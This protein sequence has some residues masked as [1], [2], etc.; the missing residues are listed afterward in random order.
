MTSIPDWTGTKATTCSWCGTDL[1]TGQERPGRTECPECGSATTDPVPDPAS[2][3]RAYGDWYWPSSGNRFGRFGDFMLRRSRASAAKRISELAPPGSI[4]D[5]GAG[6]GTLIDALGARGREASGLE[7]LP[8]RDDIVDKTIFEVEGPYAAIVFWHSLEHVP[9]A[10]QVVAEAARKLIPGGF[11]FIAVPDLAS[12]QARKFGDRWLH[13]DLPRHLVHLRSDALVAGLER[14]GFRVT[15]VSPVRGGQIV[16]GWLDGFV[17]GLPGGLNLYQALR[18]KS[19]RRIRLSP[20]QRIGSIA[21]GVLLFPLALVCA[22]AEVRSGRSGT[23][24]V[25]GQL[26]D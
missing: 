17:S 10:G 14:C 9:D 21:A 4:L 8:S 20:S 16:I 3:D 13:L 7:R 18:R 11:I 15:E 19:A 6:E 24:Y 12:R 22:A 1:A 26:R 25:E 5:V 23:V 2:L